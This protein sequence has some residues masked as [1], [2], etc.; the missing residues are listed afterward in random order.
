VDWPGGGTYTPSSG[1]WQT[2]WLEH[3]IPPTYIAAL[4]I[5]QAS[6]FQQR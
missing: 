1:I 3:D 4:L 6:R 5:N 2:V